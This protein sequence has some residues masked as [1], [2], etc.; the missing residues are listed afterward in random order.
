MSDGVFWD[1]S[2]ANSVLN[3]VFNSDATHSK[4]AHFWL[5]LTVNGFFVFFLLSLSLGSIMNWLFK[6]HMCIIEKVRINYEQ[7]TKQ[8]GVWTTHNEHASKNVAGERV[9]S[10]PG[11]RLFIG[12]CRLPNECE[13][14]CSGNKKDSNHRSNYEL[15]FLTYSM[16][17]KLV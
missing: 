11:S 17:L 13:I 8:Y 2:S 6:P 14:F 1:E 7:Y 12:T 15:F 4:N 16:F 9:I 10:Y 3:F 5:E